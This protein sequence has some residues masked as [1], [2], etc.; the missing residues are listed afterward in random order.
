MV[1]QIGG[2]GALLPLLEVVVSNILAMI[3]SNPWEKLRS[4]ISA[5]DMTRLGALLTIPLL[6]FFMVVN[7]IEVVAQHFENY[8]KELRR[9]NDALE[10]ARKDSSR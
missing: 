6:G 5:Y 9:L 4:I 10:D 3:L 7:L 2:K 8:G 1:T